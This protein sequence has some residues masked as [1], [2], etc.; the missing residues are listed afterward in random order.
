MTDIEAR[1]SINVLENDRNEILLLKRGHQTNLGPG[2]WGFPAGHIENDETPE[3]CSIRELHE[4]IGDQFEVELVNQIGPIMDSFYGGIYQI[5][6]FHYRWHCGEVH[7]NPE[8]TK[9]AWVSKEDF[10]NYSVMDGIDE[11][12]LYFGIWPGKYLNPEKLPDGAN[13]VKPKTKIISRKDRQE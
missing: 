9:Y 3:V 11:D 2:L 7:L 12:I 5:Y 1:F 8:H 10:R 13:P 6:L 4:E